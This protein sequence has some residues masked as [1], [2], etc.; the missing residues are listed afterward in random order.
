MK[1]PITY[2]VCYVCW[3]LE[4]MPHHNNPIILMLHN[5][6]I[7]FTCISS[8]HSYI[9]VKGTELVLSPYHQENSL[10]GP[11]S[12][13]MCTISH[14]DDC[15]NPFQHTHMTVSRT[16]ISPQFMLLQIPQ[17]QMYH[18]LVFKLT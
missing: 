1:W 3:I 15:Q 5:F 18:A 7:A 13:F 17:G 2:F 12:Y 8:Y 16:F 10:T 11:Q 9:T 4:Q 6:Q 14:Y